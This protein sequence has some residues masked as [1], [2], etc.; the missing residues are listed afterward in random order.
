MALIP[1]NKAF[2]AGLILLL[3]LLLSVTTLIGC[4]EENLDQDNGVTTQG[5]VDLATIK[6]GTPDQV[7]QEAVVTFVRDQSARANSGGKRQY[8]SRCNMQDGQY[9]VQVKDGAC[10]EITILYKDK[11]IAR[12]AAEMAI[13]KLLPEGA[14][15]QSRV[16]DTSLN[17]SASAPNQNYGAIYYFGDDYL[18]DLSFT[19]K[20]GSLVKSLKVSNISLFR[21]AQADS[22]AQ[23]ESLRPLVDKEKQE[24]QSTIH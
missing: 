16:D 1:T 3:P 20:S 23:K 14:P 17:Q 4:S 19:D 13:K 24:S 11:P 9:V 7:F 10:F 18:G 6:L 22:Q 2:G 21:Q 5:V 8:L 12:E 15:A